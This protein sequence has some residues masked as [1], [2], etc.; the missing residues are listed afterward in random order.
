MEDSVILRNF[1]IEIRKK[2]YE[3]KEKID[4]INIQQI[5]VSCWNDH[6]IPREEVGYKAIDIIINLIDD[7]IQ[8]NKNA[9]II[10]HCR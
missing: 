6:T 5:H 9:P 1:R 7:Y 10:I 4:I 2:I 3:E 8:N